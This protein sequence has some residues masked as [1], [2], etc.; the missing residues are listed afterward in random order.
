MR[1]PRLP[2]ILKDISGTEVDLMRFR[3][4]DFH[5]RS[6]LRP[7]DLYSFGNPKSEMLWNMRIRRKCL[8]KSDIGLFVSVLP[9]YKRAGLLIS[10]A[11]CDMEY[12][13]GNNL[14][15]QTKSLDN[16]NLFFQR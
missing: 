5:C 1:S 10:V 11:G 14:V 15:K 16:Q 6:A 8:S 9:V 4:R 7:I 2:L 12:S 3:E 13:F